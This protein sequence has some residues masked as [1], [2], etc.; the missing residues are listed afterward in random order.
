MVILRKFPYIYNE[1]LKNKC[2]LRF[3]KVLEDENNN[4]PASLKIKY[5]RTFI[6]IGKGFT[7]KSQ[8][9]SQIDLMDNLRDTAESVE[10]LIRDFVKHNYVINLNNLGTAISYKFRQI[11]GEHFGQFVEV[12]PIPLHVEKIQKFFR[13]SNSTIESFSSSRMNLRGMF[14]LNNGNVGSNNNNNIR[15]IL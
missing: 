9:N 13:D 3:C 15:E 4:I 6:K 7:T 12:L 1:T 10:I 8:L 14:E 5:C 2:F 11:V